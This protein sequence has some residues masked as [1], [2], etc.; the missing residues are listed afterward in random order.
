[1]EDEYLLR[2]TFL[3]FNSG[4]TQENP[5]PY[6]IRYLKYEHLAND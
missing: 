4:E 1:M 3:S 2:H 5:H 6:C